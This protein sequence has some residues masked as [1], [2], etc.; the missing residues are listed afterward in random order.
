MLVNNNSKCE[1]NIAA[2]DINLKK[3]LV[4]MLEQLNDNP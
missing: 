1:C 4:G 2:T 3:T